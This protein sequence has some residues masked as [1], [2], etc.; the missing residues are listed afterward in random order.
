[1]SSNIGVGLI[2][3]MLKLMALL[4]SLQVAHENR[5]LALKHQAERLGKGSRKDV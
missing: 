1:M 5:V 2:A 4:G 3:S